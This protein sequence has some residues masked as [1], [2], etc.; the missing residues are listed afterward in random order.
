MEKVD[1]KPQ[2][3]SLEDEI[4][5]KEKKRRHKSKKKKKKR[6]EIKN[7]KDQT[8]DQILKIIRK[9]RM[10]KKKNENKK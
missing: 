2:E 3:N 10:K 6:I 9:K 7:V 1:E 8:L 5:P 4:T